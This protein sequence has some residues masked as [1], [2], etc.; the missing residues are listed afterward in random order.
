MFFLFFC[1]FLFFLFLF[2]SFSVD[3]SRQ[4][5]N[6]LC[7][8][9]RHNSRWSHTRASF[10]MTLTAQ[11]LLRFPFSKEVSHEPV[12]RRPLA[13]PSRH[14]GPVGSLLLWR[15]A[16]FEIA[17]A[18]CL[19]TLG[20]LESSRAVPILMIKEILRKVLQ[21]SCQ[22]VCYR[23][24]AKRTLIESLCGDLLNRIDLFQGACTEIL[25]RG[26]LQRSCQESSYRELVQ[27]SHKEILPRFF[28]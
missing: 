3:S 21:T 23:D 26:L 4:F 19:R 1:L 20:V 7:S 10:L 14:F 8:R 24:L 12:A 11:K 27:R 13:Q 6:F 17:R 5:V 18:P 25:A 9:W 2:F 22:E 15:G 16:N 28:L